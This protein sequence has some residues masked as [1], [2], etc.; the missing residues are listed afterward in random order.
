MTDPMVSKVLE[1]VERVVVLEKD[2][3]R[4]KEKLVELEKYKVSNN[5]SPSNSIPMEKANME[6]ILRAKD[7][8]SDTEGYIDME[9]RTKRLNRL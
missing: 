2:T 7:M 6:K 9:A 5:R 8:G 3:Q 4:L 1:L